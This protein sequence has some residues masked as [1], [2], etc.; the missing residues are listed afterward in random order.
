MEGEGGKRARA[1]LGLETAQ[2]R[3][4]RVFPF[5]F[6]LFFISHFHFLFLSLFISF[7][8]ESTICKIILGVENNLC[9]VLLT[10][11]VYAYDEMT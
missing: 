9:E 2:L 1:W 5:S 8:F 4:E 3:G 6:F 11:K 7:S 10:T